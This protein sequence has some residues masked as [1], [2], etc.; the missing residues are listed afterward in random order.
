MAS[1]EPRP[2]GC[3][4]VYSSITA[5]RER[6]PG[7]QRHYADVL[8]ITGRSEAALAELRRMQALDPDSPVASNAL[9][10]QLY[11]SGRYEESLEETR[12]AVLLEPENHY[13]PWLRGIVPEA[14]GRYAEAEAAFRSDPRWTGF[15]GRLTPAVGH[16][17]AVMGRREEA[18][19]IVRQLEE[20]TSG[21]QAEH[22]SLALVHAGLGNRDAAF[23][24]LEKARKRH[25]LSVPY[26]TVDPRMAS[27]RPDPRF[28]EFVG[29]LK[30]SKP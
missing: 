12:R 6:R 4:A 16:L 1:F 25:D 15:N 28:G 8:A 23:A 10:Y 30:P 5:R 7:P 19:G 18:L 9:A 14:L 22:F 2:A 3:A 24:E 21:G 20:R 26:V 27:L 17:Y 13:T 29:R 11:A